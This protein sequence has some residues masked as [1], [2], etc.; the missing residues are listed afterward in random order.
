MEDSQIARGRG[1]LGK[2]WRLMNWA[3]IWFMIQHYGISWSM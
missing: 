3:K 2:T 1:Y